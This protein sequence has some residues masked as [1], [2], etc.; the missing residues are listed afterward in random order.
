MSTSS[1]Y[2][3]LE[4]G[5]LHLKALVFKRTVKYWLK[6]VELPD[7]HLQKHCYNRLV[8]LIENKSIPFNWLAQLKQNL[9]TIGAWD[10]RYLCDSSLIKSNFNNIIEKYSNHCF[11][12]DI[13]NILNSKYNTYFRDISSLGSSSEVYLDKN[14][15]SYIRLF[16][17]IRLASSKMPILYVN[18]Q[19]T[20]FSPNKPCPTCIGQSSDDLE[21]FFVSCPFYVTLRGRYIGECLGNHGNIKQLLILND[22]AQLRKLYLFAVNALDK[23][24]RWT[25]LINMA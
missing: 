23:R 17:Q 14:K 16:S 4:T 13:D 12:K 25:S 3:R 6:L 8:Q 5:S 10:D 11:S 24:N 19:R 2:I 1:S 21:H 20:I 7:D 15:V 9:L 22:T 18:K